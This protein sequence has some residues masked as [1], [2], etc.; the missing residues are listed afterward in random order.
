MM[1]LKIMIFLHFRMMSMDPVQSD[2]R[3]LGASHM[4]FV[5]F[6]YDFC[7]VHIWTSQKWPSQG[8]WYSPT[9]VNLGIKSEKVGA[10]SCRAPVRRNNYCCY[11]AAILLLSLS[12]PLSLSKGVVIV[13]VIVIERCC[14]RHRRSLQHPHPSTATVWWEHYHH[15]RHKNKWIRIKYYHH[16]HHK[17]TS[18]LELNCE[19]TSPGRQSQRENVRIWSQSWLVLGFDFFY[20]EVL[21]CT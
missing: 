10:S 14:A 15:L 9:C 13:T 8:R 17:K 2:L 19:W 12:L 4:I 3:L 1:S 21:I 16:L 18:G 7:D 11:I 6:R 20:L 5:M